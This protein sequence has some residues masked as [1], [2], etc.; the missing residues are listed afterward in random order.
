MVIG[1]RRS[2]VIVG[3]GQLGSRYLQGLATCSHRL[4]IQVVD[5][6]PKAL[7]TA[8]DRWTIVG[9]AGTCHEVSF[10]QGIGEVSRQVE[11]A[12]VATTAL[13]RSEVVE[14]IGAHADVGSWILEKVL[15]QGEDELCRIVAAVGASMAWV[16]TWGR[17]TPWYQQIRG[18]EVVGPIRFHLV[19]ASWGM[20][21]NAIHFLDL[22]CW[23]T[24]EDLVEVDAAGLDD[25]WLI[26]KRPGFMEISGD[27]FARYSGGS[28]G[29][30]RAGRPP[31]PGISAGRDALDVLDV[32]WSSGR[33]Q[34]E[35]PTSEEDGLAIAADGRLL[36][37]RI[38]RQSERSAALVDGLLEGSGCSLTDLPTS[39]AQH[40]ILIRAL[41]ARWREVS[42]PDAECVPIT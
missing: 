2:I 36:P 35:R 10:H 5:P 40:G 42:G 32:E 15:A 26:A 34:I 11:I 19:G 1:E 4:R 8:A 13:R 17:S 9:G 22:M 38:E 18:S 16:N 20:A 27:L 14:A 25:E 7:A 33:W 23:W 24:G 39:V 41:L 6:A 37:G 31:D 30:L 12:I 3:A 21:C 29:V 28:T